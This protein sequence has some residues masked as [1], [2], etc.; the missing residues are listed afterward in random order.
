[1]PEAPPRITGFQKFLRK[2][3]L[4]FDTW[5]PWDQKWLLRKLRPVKLRLLEHE[6]IEWCEK[7]Y[8]MNERWGVPSYGR[9]DYTDYLLSRKH[10]VVIAE[11]E[12]GRIGTFGIHRIDA[13]DAYVSYVMVDPGARRSGVGTTMMLAAIALLGTESSEQNI[14]LT[15]FP[16]SQPFYRKLGFASFHQE[17]VKNQTL[18]YM[19]LGPITIPLVCDC[20]EMLANAK[21][22]LPRLPFPLPIAESPLPESMLAP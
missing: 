20:R 14:V 7:L 9:E 1:M 11:D 12:H 13:Q 10:V 16:T 21:V 15:A 5:Y 4:F 3:R 8:E 18:A 6:D 2:A 17:S 19:A 22:T